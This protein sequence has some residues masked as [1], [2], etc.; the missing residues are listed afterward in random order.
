MSANGIRAGEWIAR[1][2]PR[3]AAILAGDIRNAATT[4]SLAIGELGEDLTP[5]ETVQVAG[6]LREANALILSL[7]Y[8]LQPGGVM[9]PLPGG[10]DEAS[11]D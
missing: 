8:A 5:A 10:S 1:L 11:D 6:S 9:M 3:R 7:V 2:Q 4:V